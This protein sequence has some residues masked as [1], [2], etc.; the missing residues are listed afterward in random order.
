ML[1]SDL[2][3]PTNSS[4]DI[5]GKTS[6][7]I[8][9]PLSSSSFSTSTSRYESSVMNKYK[10]LVPSDFTHPLSSLKQINQILSDQQANIKNK[11]VRYLSF[12][13]YITTINKKRFYRLF[14]SCQIC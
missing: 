14:L 13:K 11:Y 10:H 2:S 7:I 12:S 5:N 1:N 8:T 4:Y 3:S 6:V 9:N